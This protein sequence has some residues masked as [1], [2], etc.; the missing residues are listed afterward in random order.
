ML[1]I[2]NVSAVVDTQE[3][4]N[5]INIEIKA[6]EIHAIMGPRKSGKSTLAHLIQGN[7]YIEITSGSITYKNKSITKVSAHKRS[8]LGIFTSFQHPPEIDGLTNL[9]L[10]KAIYEARNGTDFGQELEKAYR[11]LVNTIGLDNLFPDEPVNTCARH[12][13]DWKKGEIIQMLMLQPDLA[14]LDEIDLETTPE[15]LECIVAMIKSYLELPAKSLVV[16][17][18]NKEL[19]EKLNPAHVHVLVDGEIRAT[20][21]SELYKRIIEDGYPQLS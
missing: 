12:P 17:T 7:P 20:G 2:K 11:E 3:V 4:L 8:K 14:V 10:L 9:E 5:D 15:A 21:T 19:L 18:H 1:K 13:E 6:G 16:I